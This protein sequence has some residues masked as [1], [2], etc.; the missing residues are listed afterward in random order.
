MVSQ[1]G[2]EPA[3]IPPFEFVFPNTNHFPTAGAEGA[4]D[5]AIAGLVGRNLL[6]PERGVVLGF[7][8]VLGATVPEAAVDKDGELQPGK[9][10]SGRTAN[11]GVCQSPAL[12]PPLA[13]RSLGEAGSSVF[14]P[15]ITAPRRQPVMP[16]AR[17]I[18]ISR[19]SV[20]WLPCARMAAITAERLRLEK[21]SIGGLKPAYRKSGRALL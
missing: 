18:A 3:L 1:P 7:R 6:P 12:R 11:R 15:L 5:E 20:V 17:K 21:M 10:K 4:G 13:L 2:E 16:C 19:S 8:A 14:R 9:T